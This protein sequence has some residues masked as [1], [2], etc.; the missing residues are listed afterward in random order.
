MGR[1]NPFSPEE[2]RD[3]FSTISSEPEFLTPDICDFIG[4]LPVSAEVRRLSLS[5][6]Q[7]ITDEEV[8]TAVKTLRRWS[9]THCFENTIY[10]FPTCL[11]CF[12][13]GT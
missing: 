6:D 11:P 9:A 7:D 13:F 12:E 1:Q 2:R 3:H 8:Q 4:T 5:L 10:R